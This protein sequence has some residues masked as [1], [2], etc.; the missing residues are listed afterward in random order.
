MLTT[1]QIC[2]S[3]RYRLFFIFNVIFINDYSQDKC[4]FIYHDSYLHVVQRHLIITYTGTSVIANDPIILVW[5]IFIC[6]NNNIVGLAGTQL[7]GRLYS[8]EYSRIIHN[9]VT[10]SERMD[11]LAQLPLY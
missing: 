5:V 9:Y 6:Q 8:A 7:N 2:L 11:N 4:N 3:Y 10:T 1:I